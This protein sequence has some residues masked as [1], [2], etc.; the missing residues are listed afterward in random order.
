MV[1]GSA[2]LA[3]VAVARLHRAGVLPGGSAR[4]ER[5]NHAHRPVTLTEG[6]A[7]V[8]GT[9]TPLLVV[10]PPAALAVLGAGVAGAVDDLGGTTSTK[11]LRGHLRPL[12]RGEVTTGAL[13]VVGLGLSGLLSCGWSD[14]RTGR[15]LGSHTLTGAALVAG[16]ANLANLFDLRPGR[17]LKVGLALAVPLGLLGRPGAAAVSGAGAALL[18]ADLRGSSML[19]DTGANPLG[20]VVGLA[21][22]QALGPRGRVL[23]LAAVTALNLASERVSFSRVIDSHPVLSALDRWGRPR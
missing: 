10:D 7:L 8:G 13:K 19:G 1:A 3:S 18:P 9:C 21:A 11:G 4:W 12:R 23:A 17:A 16:S 6:V 5:T 2:A 14:V 20:A 15:G 22:A